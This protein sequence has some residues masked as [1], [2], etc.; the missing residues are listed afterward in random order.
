MVDRHRAAD[1]E[2]ELHELATLIDLVDRLIQ[3]KAIRQMDLMSQ[4]KR[5]QAAEMGP[6]RQEL[7]VLRQK[8]L[9]ARTE[10]T[11]SC[12]TCGDEG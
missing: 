4:G 10:A 3:E 7:A 11:S 2:V 1:L 8:L 12:E 5:F 9:L 6:R